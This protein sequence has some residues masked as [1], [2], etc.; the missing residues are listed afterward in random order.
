MYIYN[1]ICLSYAILIGVGRGKDRERR[2]RE[3]KRGLITV[4]GNPIHF[5]AVFKI[6]KNRLLLLILN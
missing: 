4:G 1:S 6:I 5:H 3:R 2:E